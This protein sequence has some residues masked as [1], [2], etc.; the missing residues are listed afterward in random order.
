MNALGKLARDKRGAL[1]EI[2]RR[3]GA[4][5]A[6]VSRVAQGKSRPSPELARK[7]EAATGGAVTAAALLGVDPAASTAQP[8]EDG[9]WFAD[10][11]A[12]NGVQLPVE[13][14]RAFGFEE[15]DAVV[16]RPTEDGVVIT[17]QQRALRRVQEQLSKLAPN[18]EDVVDELIAERRAEAARE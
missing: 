6:Q 12:D 2:A 16:F 17:S 18:E 14:L 8:L 9:R 10:V 11:Q 15:G 13:M 3:V 5:H 7:I 1:A 4:S